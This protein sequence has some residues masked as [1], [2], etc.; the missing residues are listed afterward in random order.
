MEI[1]GNISKQIERLMKEHNV[2]RLK[3]SKDTGIPYT[4]LTQIINGRTKNPQVK[5]L[6]TIAEYFQVSLDYLL[7]QSFSALMEKRLSELNMSIDDL[8]KATDLPRLLLES[9]ETFPNAPW[10]FEAGAIIDRIS[11]ALKMDYK[12]LAMAWA[13]QEPPV[14]DGPQDSRS[15]EEIFVNEEFE[16]YS[17]EPKTDSSLSSKEERDIAVD[18]ER[19]IG[20]LESNEAMAFHGE[21]MDEETKELMRIS[22]ENSLRLAKQMA[23]QK[24]NPNK[25]K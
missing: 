14:Y 1:S 25:N 10:D 7:G 5:A 15:I 13:R 2:T 18:L 6:E 17:Y 9:L 3:L 11:T 23:K 19:M 12:T 8:S 16:Q 22:L 20:E 21:P 4:T 24:F